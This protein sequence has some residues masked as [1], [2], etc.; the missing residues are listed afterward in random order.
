MADLAA[1][2]G[3]WGG[4]Q[5][6]ARPV[7]RQNRTEVEP[8]PSVGTGQFPG[9]GCNSTGVR[10]CRQSTW[11]TSSVGGGLTR[12]RSRT[13]KWMAFGIPSP[14]LGQ[15][16]RSR[17]RWTHETALLTRIVGRGSRYRRSARTALAHERCVGESR[18]EVQEGGIAVHPAL[19]GSPSRKFAFG[20][21][22]WLRV[23]N[24]RVGHS[25]PPLGRRRAQNPRGR[26]RG[27]QR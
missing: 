21:S 25:R 14:V 5:E 23:R 15:H 6:A 27:L 1:V 19:A 3:P 24:V 9:R 10:R 20:W 4:A 11:D 2:A 7:I 8:R 18:C 17:R 16:G 26:R 12:G 13:P 22:G